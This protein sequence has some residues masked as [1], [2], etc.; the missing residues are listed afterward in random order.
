RERAGFTDPEALTFNG[1]WT[2]EEL[3]EIIR[4]ERRSELA[5]EGLRIFD[6][7]R[8]RIAEDVLNRTPHGARFG[9]PGVDDGYIRL[10]A[11]S[12]NSE[13]DYLWAVPQSQRDLNPNLGQNPSW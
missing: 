3:R 10:D 7:R 8:W 4:T 9:Q 6:L 11:R 13:R 2:Q 1:A 12:F 5:V